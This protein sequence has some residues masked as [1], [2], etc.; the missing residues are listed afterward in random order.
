M[1]RWA[2]RTA[3]RSKPVRAGGREPVSPRR[4]LARRSATSRSA[5]RTG[6]G[7]S[8]SGRPQV[9]AQSAK[10][11]VE[12]RLAGDLRF[13][14]G[15]RYLAVK[16]LG[17]TRPPAIAAK[18]TLAKAAKP[19]QKPPKPG[20]DHPARSD[21]HAAARQEQR[22][23]PT[24]PFRSRPV[25]AAEPR[26]SSEA[27]SFRHL[28]HGRIRR[29]ASAASPSS[30]SRAVRKPSTRKELTTAVVDPDRGPARCQVTPVLVHPKGNYRA[31]LARSS[32]AFPSGQSN[33]YPVLVTVARTTRPHHA[34]QPSYPYAFTSR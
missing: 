18:A 6:A 10:V 29:R 22:L 34:F 8:Q 23:G 11:D 31:R 2:G 3:E 16:P 25:P 28:R 30:G 26:R 32:Q 5:S 4:R 9:F 14:L 17:K 1:K 20:P 7:R 15:D 13:C 33:E 24:G 19:R 21:F 12:R 27:T